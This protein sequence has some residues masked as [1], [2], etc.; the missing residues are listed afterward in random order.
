MKV[1]LLVA[2]CRAVLKGF[3]AGFWVPMT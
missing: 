2:A 1:L 3:G